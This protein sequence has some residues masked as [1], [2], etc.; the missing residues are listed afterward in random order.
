MVGKYS[1]VLCGDMINVS[2]E[3]ME[4]AARP[5]IGRSSVFTHRLLARIRTAETT[6]M[7]ESIGPHLLKRGKNR[8]FVL[9]QT[10]LPKHFPYKE[11]SCHA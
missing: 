1:E 4:A 10:I 6:N 9:E 3:C 2:T 7:T 8:D 5:P 11:Q